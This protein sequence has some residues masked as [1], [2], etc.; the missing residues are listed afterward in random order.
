MALVLKFSS[1]VRCIV[2]EFRLGQKPRSNVSFEKKNV[3]KIDTV[4]R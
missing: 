1:V 2:E 3:Y 4:L